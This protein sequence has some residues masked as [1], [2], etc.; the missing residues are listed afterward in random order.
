M[1]GGAMMKQQGAQQA[2]CSASSNF[3]RGSTDRTHSSGRQ[4][5]ATPA[6][7]HS[8]PSPPADHR[9]PVPRP[10]LFSA[11]ELHQTRSARVREREDAAQGRG[12][13]RRGG[14]CGAEAESTGQRWRRCR[15]QDMHCAINYTEGQGRR[16]EG[17]RIL[18]LGSKEGL[19]VERL[20]SQSLGSRVLAS[21]SR[22]ENL[23]S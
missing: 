12:T 20:G 9:P 19:R 14:G 13:G 23:G 1:E 16:V 3:G 21:G 18:G 15:A 6:P 5:P 7:Q 11:A 22:V 17:S 4:H 2:V 8:S 10:P